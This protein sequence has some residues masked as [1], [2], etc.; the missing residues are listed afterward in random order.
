MAAYVLALAA[1]SESTSGLH[2]GFVVFDEPLQQN[3]DK[4]HRDLFV[5]FLISDTA[6]ALKGQTIVFTWLHDDELERLTRAG[7]RLV[8]PRGDHF[9]ELIPPP[10]EHR[11]KKGDEGRDGEAEGDSP[12]SNGRV[13]RGS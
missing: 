6:L 2:P 13:V 9:L 7:V 10:P 5:D 4:K 12:T 1:A 11:P 3:P 8:N